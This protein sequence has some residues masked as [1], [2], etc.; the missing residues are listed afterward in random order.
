MNLA[1]G[2]LLRRPADRDVCGPGVHE[3]RWRPLWL[4]TLGK[5]TAY[6]CS[7]AGRWPAN[8]ITSCG[9]ILIWGTDS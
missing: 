5:G 3:L 7:N 6:G 4:A 9:T 1:G 2:G 8:R